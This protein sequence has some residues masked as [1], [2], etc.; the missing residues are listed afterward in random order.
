MI[1]AGA[2]I[3]SII[4]RGL[5]LKDVG[6]F[7]LSHQVSGMGAAQSSAAEAP[8]IQQGSSAFSPF[9]HQTFAVLW[10]ATVVSNIGTW[11]QSAAVGWY[12]T[13]LDPHPFIVSLVRVASSL[14]MFLLA[15]PAGALG[16]IVDRRK[17]IIVIQVVVTLLVL[18]F[19]IMIRMALVTPYLL[20]A[21]VFVATSAAALIM[22]VWQ[23]I[24]PQLVPK[25]L[26]QPAVALNSVGVNV[27]R[28][29]GPALAGVIIAGWG[30][31]APFWLN[32]FSNVGV[33]AALF[34][35]RQKE[36]GAIRNFPPEKF[37]MAMGAGLRYARHNH[38]LRATQIRALGFF[39]FASAYWALL[40]LVA[41]DQVAGGSAL[42]GILLGA[43]GIGA[44]AGAIVLPLFKRLLGPDRL[45]DAGS[46]GTAIA[47]LLFALA[48]N[49]ELALVASLIAGVSWI[50]VLATLNISAQVSLPEWVRSRGLSIYNTVMFGSMTFGGAIWGKIAEWDGLPAAHIVAALGVLIAAA[51]SW[52][53]K[54]ET[55]AALDLTPSNPWSAPST[56]QA[57]KPDRGPV[58]VTIEYHIHPKDRDDFISAVAHLAGER[59]RDGAFAWDIYEDPT[60]SDRFVECF[61]LASWAE[62]LRQHE[63]VTEADRKMQALV[64]RFQIEGPPRVT[65]LIAAE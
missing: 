22:P 49:S 61:L 32:A 54:L 56:A 39:V 53:S 35:W 45:V 11:M 40:P 62:H 44:V 27:S 57:V 25:A 58:L 7:D 42:Y 59:R 43:I 48:K 60:R 36:S 21:F 33:I 31:A 65:H 24:V 46:G 52:R 51:L 1:G 64:N 16:D 18:A 29:V 9:L 10:C 41:R 13:I 55:G 34:R 47:L 23:S 15:I 12:M 14:P 26:L 38:P 3:R 19:V 5:A 30:I 37:L 20:L 8:R 28:A 17:L 50:A 63:R 6:I 2:G 4:R